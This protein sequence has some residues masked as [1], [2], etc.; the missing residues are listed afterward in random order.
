[1]KK[2]KKVS[3]LLVGIFYSHFANAE[4]TV[5]ISINP[6]NFSTEIANQ[7][8]FDCGVKLVNQI[9]NVPSS[10]GDGTLTN[11]THSFSTVI[12]EGKTSERYAFGMGYYNSRPTADNIKG[13]DARVATA[14]NTLFEISFWKSF[15]D[16]IIKLNSTLPFP[17]LHFTAQ[18]IPQCTFDQWGVK[19]CTKSKYE[20]SSIYWIVP[21][22][23]GLI[24][25]WQNSETK[26]EIKPTSDFGEFMKCVE[27]K[28]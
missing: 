13:L 7:A 18:E 12:G 15:G 23:G 22:S 26:F 25:N 10:L 3:L 17:L 24:S 11:T 20:Y 14:Q 9:I 5:P 27:S 4:T 6:S 19:T 8:L 1:M 28:L 2:F 16:S 21:D